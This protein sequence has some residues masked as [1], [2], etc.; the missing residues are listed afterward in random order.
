MVTEVSA[1]LLLVVDLEATCDGGSMPH[2]QRET[3]E[4]GAV[5]I[6]A[7]E[8]EVVREFQAFVKPVRHPELTPYCT[9]LTG[10][11]QS[12]V[13]SAEGFVP[14]FEEFLDTMVHGRDVCF[15]SWGG[16]DLRQLSRDAAYHSITNPIT[17]ALDLSLSFT[18]AAG[19]TRRPSMGNAMGMVGLTVEGALHRGIDDARNLVRLVPWCLG[20]KAIDVS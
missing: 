14:V 11:Q 16:F 15:A 19:L 3:I 13:H 20:R 8:L 4:I 18:K 10:I 2:A 1:E 9:E 6:T 17:N 12:D 5:L 7:D